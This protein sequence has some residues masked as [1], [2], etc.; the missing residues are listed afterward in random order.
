MNRIFRVPLG[1]AALLLVVTGSAFAVAGGQSADHR[2]PVAASH[3][4]AQPTD[5][6][7][8]QDE[9]DEAEGATPSDALLSR[10]EDATGHDAAEIAALAADYGVGGAVRI[11]AWADAT[12]QDAGAI[13]ALFDGGMGWGEIARELDPDD[14]LGLSPGIGSVMGNGASAAASHGQATAPGQLKKQQ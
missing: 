1:I 2:S 4:P 11:L 10:L 14:E 9:A 12:G 7:E 3:Q 8:T 6:A 13:G 5:S